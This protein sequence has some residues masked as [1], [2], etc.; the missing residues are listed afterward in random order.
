[1]KL[2][3]KFV[4]V[5]K[6]EEWTIATL[7][8]IRKAAVNQR[9]EICNRIRGTLSEFCIISAKGEGIS[10]IISVKC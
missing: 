1:M 7:H 10:I 2:Y 9:I 5:K 6:A 4:R 3:T 8:T